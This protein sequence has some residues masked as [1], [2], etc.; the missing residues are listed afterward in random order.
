MVCRERPTRAVRSWFRVVMILAVFCP[1]TVPKMG[2]MA[3]EVQGRP[4]DRY[5]DG[6][7]VFV[8]ARERPGKRKMPLVGAPGDHKGCPTGLRTAF[9]AQSM[10]AWYTSC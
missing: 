9:R 10:M 2:V 8:K 3:Q 5:G 6:S 7:R 1:G 4:G